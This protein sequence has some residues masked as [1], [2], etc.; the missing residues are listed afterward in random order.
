MSSFKREAE[1]TR[2]IEQLS[3]LVDELRQLLSQRD[4]ELERLMENDVENEHL[5]VARERKAAAQEI[6]DVIEGHGLSFTLKTVA[7]ICDIRHAETDD[8]FWRKV[9]KQLTKAA[10]HVP[11]E[12]FDS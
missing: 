2:I 12:G 7:R 6:E 1:A 10:E 11:D 8:P 5:L 3:G 9:A 4:A